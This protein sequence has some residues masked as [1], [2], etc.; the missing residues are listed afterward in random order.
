MSC[1]SNVFIQC[2]VLTSTDQFTILAFGVSIHYWSEIYRWPIIWSN[3][4]RY[5]FRFPI[6]GYQ[7]IRELHIPRT[8]PTVL[9]LKSYHLFNLNKTILQYRFQHE[10]PILCFVIISTDQLNP[11]AFGFHLRHTDVDATDLGMEFDSLIEVQ[12]LDVLSM[13]LWASHT[14]DLVYCNIPQEFNLTASKL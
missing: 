4:S 13:H 11:L 3:N 14:R 6:S 10:Q 2:F 12:G 5:G 1:S 9:T 8:L 7:C